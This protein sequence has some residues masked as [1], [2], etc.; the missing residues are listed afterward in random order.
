M[1]S[2][3]S[4]WE[5]FSFI[6]CE[7]PKELA[8]KHNNGGI[9]SSRIFILVHATI[10]PNGLAG[11]RVVGETKTYE[12]DAISFGHTIGNKL[13][14]FLDSGIDREKLRIYQQEQQEKQ[15]T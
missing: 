5:N 6:E 11:Q 10:L 1:I 13:I 12:T 14:S 15:K 9:A 8:Y 7:F 4:I 2:F 3:I